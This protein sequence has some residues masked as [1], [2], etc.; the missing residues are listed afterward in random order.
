VRCI[1]LTHTTRPSMN[2]DEDT[3][4]RGREDEEEQDSDAAEAEASEAEASDDCSA[5]EHEDNDGDVDDTDGASG[6]PLVQQLLEDI[7]KQLQVPFSVVQVTGFVCFFFLDFFFTGWLLK[8]NKTQVISTWLDGFRT[9]SFWH[10][11]Q[12][13]F[14]RIGVTLQRLGLADENARGMGLMDLRRASCI[15]LELQVK[16]LLAISSSESIQY[17]LCVV[18]FS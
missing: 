18:L 8:K 5:Y 11:A 1:L 2:S 9:G 13:F 14:I 7:Q 10:P 15:T 3:M 12:G 4:K 17:V 16:E 6:V